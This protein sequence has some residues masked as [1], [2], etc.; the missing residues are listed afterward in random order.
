[1]TLRE[2][3]I[4]IIMGSY[5]YNSLADCGELGDLDVSKL[6]NENLLELFTKVVTYIE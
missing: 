1:M 6:D 3:I 4:D 5:W 2:M